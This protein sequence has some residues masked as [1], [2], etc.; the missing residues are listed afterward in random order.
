VLFD[1]TD[2]SGWVG[3]NAQPA[4]WKLENGYMEV[5]PGSGNI[6]TREEFGDCQLHLEFASPVEVKA[7]GRGVA[8]AASS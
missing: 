7:T 2:L 3:G 8:T 5:V 4:P 6:R 1:G